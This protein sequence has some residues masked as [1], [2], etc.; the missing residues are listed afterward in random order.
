MPGQSCGF[1]PMCRCV[2]PAGLRCSKLKS[3]SHGGSGNSAEPSRCEMHYATILTLLSWM[4]LS[5]LTEGTMLICSR[6]V[7]RNVPKIPQFPVHLSCP[8]A[9]ISS[10]LFGVLSKPFLCSLLHCCCRYLNL[11]Q[12]LCEW[13]SFQVP[14]TSG[15]RQI[16]QQSIV[17]I[18]QLRTIPSISYHS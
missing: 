4:S 16:S 12:R 7:P 9:F 17:H 5:E 8:S 6:G 14:I 15:V 1:V 11:S 2:W 10:V 3:S 13:L 18:C